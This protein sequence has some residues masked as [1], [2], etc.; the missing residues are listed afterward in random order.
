MPR[1]AG[2]RTIIEPAILL[3]LLD[4]HAEYVVGG[5]PV[6]RR[7]HI[8]GVPVGDSDARMIRRWRAGTIQ[9]V[10]AKSA[11][12]LLQRHRLDPLT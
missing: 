4:D 1:R 8:N 12:A 9:G 10:T 3:E 2:P 11:N 6:R 7:L 5:H